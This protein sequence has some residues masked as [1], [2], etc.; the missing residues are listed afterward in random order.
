[1]KKIAK[2]QSFLFENGQTCDILKDSIKQ[3]GGYY[4][5]ILYRAIGKTKSNITDND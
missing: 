3:A 5:R 1:M 2:T 4:E